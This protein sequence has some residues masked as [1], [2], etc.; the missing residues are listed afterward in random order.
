ML[1]EWP[2]TVGK[3]VPLPARAPLVAVETASDTE[4]SRAITRF[5]V[6]TSGAERGSRIRILIVDDSATIRRMV[7]A[8][9]RGLGDV[10]FAEAGSGLEAVERLAMASTAMMLL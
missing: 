1:T 8:S 7:V 10:S 9:L 2:A 4:G 5:G 6:L 3:R